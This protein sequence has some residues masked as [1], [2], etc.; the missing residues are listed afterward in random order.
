MSHS[1][2]TPQD[3]TA[4]V[5]VDFD[6][7]VASGGYGDVYKGRL[8]RD[9]DGHSGE[10]AVKVTRFIFANIPEK[11]MKAIKRELD[12]W[13]QH[14][15]PYI[16]P[17]IGVYLHQNVPCAISPWCDSGTIIQYMKS[18]RGGHEPELQPPV[19][20]CEFD[21]LRLH[22]LEFKLLSEVA[23][24]LAYL[25][26]YN[27]AHGDIKASNILVKGGVAQLG[28]FGFS[29]ILSEHTGSTSSHLGT[30]RWFAPESLQE[31][32]H[33]T[34]EADVWAFGCA[35]LEVRTLLVPYHR[36]PDAA[37]PLA[38]RKNPPYERPKDIH[39]S[40]WS[41]AEACWSRS[42]KARIVS[43]TLAS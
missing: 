13:Q 42:P 9:V 34:Q 8:I 4:T 14:R 15:H 23:A 19:T 39:P 20:N 31:H 17:L 43:P 7:K 3:L 32:A 6:R 18:A 26:A 27:L 29:V 24:G 28:D 10:V 1:L 30:A 40:L 16:L 38:I 2:A 5:V 25:H 37:V 21:L 33:R 36:V 12:I 22:C 11:V 35:I 41:M